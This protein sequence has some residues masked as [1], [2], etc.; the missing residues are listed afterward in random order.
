M[1]NDEII[2]NDVWTFKSDNVAKNFDIHVR[3]SV[4]LYDELQRMTLELSQYFIRDN[5]S[6][7][8]L[9]ISTGTTFNKLNE[10]SCRKNLNYLGIDESNQ[11]IEQAKNNLQHISKKELINYDLNK[12]LPDSEIKGPFS[13]VTSIFTLQFVYL[14]NRKKLLRE[15]YEKLRDGGAV[16]L[17]EKILGN[18]S[19][20]N[21]MMID[22]YQD[23]KIRN[24]LDPTNN[25]K[26]SKSLRGIM[27][28]LLLDENKRLLIA[29]GFSR[30]DVF[31]K[32]YNFVGII[33]VK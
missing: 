33:A 23:M 2:Y 29:T 14:E 8:D 17:I 13:L 11:M 24:G 3:Q 6:V 9:G 5:D 27:S 15:V 1:D 20:F 22:L 7:M 25:Q 12:G 30:I 21:E 26:K 28:P 32:W 4:P 31:F 16:I 19:H 18:D 10:S